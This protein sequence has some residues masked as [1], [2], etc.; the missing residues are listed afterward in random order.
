[1]SVNPT[2]LIVTLTPKGLFEMI[3]NTY[4]NYLDYNWDVVTHIIFKG[5]IINQ[6]D[7]AQVMTQEDCLS[8][9]EAASTYIDWFTVLKEKYPHL[10]VFWQVADQFND[11]YAFQ[12]SFWVSLPTVL[13]QTRADGIYVKLHGKC[14]IQ[15]RTCQV[16]IIIEPIGCEFRVLSFFQ[17]FTSILV[18]NTNVFYDDEHPEEIINNLVD[19]IDFQKAVLTFEPSMLGYKKYSDG[20]SH[21][22]TYPIYHLSKFLFKGTKVGGKYYKFERYFNNDI[23]VSTLSLN[24]PP[25]SEIIT[26]DSVKT[27]T[28]KMELVFKYDFK[29]CIIG[30]ISNDF[31]CSHKSSFISIFTEFAKTH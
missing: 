18:I 4:N 15:L 21:Y 25:Y 2:L 8:Y 30:D 7:Y 24:M 9:F 31:F 19:E 5:L 13:C 29:G 12:D 27:R 28:K 10:K 3:S 6:E 16:P 1:M 11:F 22:T 26:F 23:G 14:E 17:Q 20:N